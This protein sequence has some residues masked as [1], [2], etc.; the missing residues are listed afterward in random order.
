MSK[1]DRDDNQ[2][3]GLELLAILVGLET[4]THKLKGAS[5]RIWTDNAGG[6]LALKKQAGKASDHNALVHLVWTKAAQINAGLYI[7]RVPSCESIAD[8]PTTPQK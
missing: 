7:N 2:I 1:P 3:M 8:G 5:V 6:E 4:F